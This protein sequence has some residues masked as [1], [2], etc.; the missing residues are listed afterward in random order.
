V[1][2]LQDLLH[3]ATDRID[4][5][6]LAS[7]ALAV[8]LQR[9]RSRRAGVV[10]ST[11]AVVL[12]VGLA[13]AGWMGDTTDGP[14]PAPPVGTD[15]PTPLDLQDVADL[16]RADPSVEPLLPAR[17][18]VPDLAPHVEDDPVGAAV[19]SID[20]GADVLLLGTDGEWRCVVVEG[21]T[22][23]APMLSPRG[24]RLA[25][26]TTDGVVTVDLA[27]GAQSRRPLPTGVAPTGAGTVVMSWLDERR[28][29][30]VDGGGGRVVDVVRDTEEGVADP[31]SPDDAWELGTPAVTGP[32]GWTLRP[33]TPL[34][35]GTGL[36]QVT[37]GQGGP[38]RWWLVHW[39]P[40]TD[41]L[42]LVSTIAASSWKPTSYARE[43]LAR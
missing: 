7:G 26:A 20:D 31:P 32:A 42:A 18:D 23:P 38:G 34:A 13:V 28:L 6:D 22:Q 16:P 15:V 41:A 17:L 12:V 1:T 2:E 25:V 40:A 21:R 30:F 4:G 29:L 24:T 37:R 19:L 10:A 14:R 8:A 35:D 39:D 3:R 11:A 36:L 43:L 9:R 5:P 27:S 33:V